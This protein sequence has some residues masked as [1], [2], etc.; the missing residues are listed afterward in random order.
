M[1]VPFNG[2]N[3][4]GVGLCCTLTAWASSQSWYL[5]GVSSQ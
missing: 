3:E 4:A 2:P 5:S 1:I